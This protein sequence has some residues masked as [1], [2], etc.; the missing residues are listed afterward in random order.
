MAYVDNILKLFSHY[1]SYFSVSNLK[2]QKNKV[3]NTSSGLNFVHIHIHFLMFPLQK[4][5]LKI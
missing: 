3:I 5:L 1:V 2:P 4:H